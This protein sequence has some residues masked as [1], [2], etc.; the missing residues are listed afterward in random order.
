MFEHNPVKYWGFKR[1]SALRWCNYSINYFVAEVDVWWFYNQR[2]AVKLMLGF[3]VVMLMMIGLRIGATNSMARIKSSTDELSENRLPS[4][5]AVMELRINIGELRRFQLAHVMS[6]EPADIK[7]ME[8]LV[9]KSML[10]LNKEKHALAR[11]KHTV[12]HAP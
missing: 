5:R 11:V 4:V 7:R 12:A 9:E 6:A 2:I 1:V 3:G 8:N 10:A